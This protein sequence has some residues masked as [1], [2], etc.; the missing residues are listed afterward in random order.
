MSSSA[1]GLAVL[2]LLL[3]LSMVPN[4][5]T[6]DESESQ[7]D[8]V[9]AS[10]IPVTVSV[11]PQQ[12]FVQR[13]GGE[14]VSVNVMIPPGHSPASYEPSPKQMR[15]LSR[16][17]LYFRIGHIPFEQVWMDNIIASNPTLKVVDTSRGVALIDTRRSDNHK[18]QGHEHDHE[19]EHQH[20]SDDNHVHTGIDPHI[21]LSPHA[22]KIQSRHIR[23]TLIAID[24]DH[25]EIYR[26]NYHTFESDIDRLYGEIKASFNGLEGRK[27]MVFHPAWGYFARDFGLQQLPVEV[28]GKTP[29]PAI[30]KQV[31]DTARQEKI[32]VI[33]VQRQFDTHSA[34]AV[35]A[36]I[37]GRVIQLDP[38]APDWLANMK[39]IAS[40][41]QEA[42][43]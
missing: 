29:S 2:V 14:R 23:D 36:D 12:Y 25:E 10:I 4:C 5:T 3:I 17:V 41:L 1:T 40:A 20:Q 19:T 8:G 13:I 39:K 21:W 9:T 24:P 37:N 22:V 31:I 15:Q 7:A 33:F 27:F 43:K 38:L 35:A 6:K 16:S 11:L 34:E 18:E 42:L 26:S 28:G 32:Q 30:L